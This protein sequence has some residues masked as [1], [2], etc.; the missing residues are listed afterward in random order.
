MDIGT[1]I[2]WTFAAF[3]IVWIAGIILNRDL[4]P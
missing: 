2:L 1:I 3:G 4:L